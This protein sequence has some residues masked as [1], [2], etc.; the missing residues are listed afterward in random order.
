MMEG[1]M[2]HLS[3]L[4]TAKTLPRTEQISLVKVNDLNSKVAAQIA[5]SRNWATGKSA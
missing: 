3:G 1:A 5:H 4:A 2:I